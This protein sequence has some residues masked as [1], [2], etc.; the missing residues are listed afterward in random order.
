MNCESTA[1]RKPCNQEIH[2]WPCSKTQCQLIKENHTSMDKLC[3]QFAGE[4]KL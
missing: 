3:A 4:I 2:A 1:V